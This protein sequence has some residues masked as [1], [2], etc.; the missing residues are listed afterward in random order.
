MNGKERIIVYPE[1]LVEYPKGTH[2]PME[3]MIEP[4]AQS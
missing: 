4:I 1:F 3:F 2:V